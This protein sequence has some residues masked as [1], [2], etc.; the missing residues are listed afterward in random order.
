MPVLRD[1]LTIYRQQGVG[2][3]THSAVTFLGDVLPVERRPVSYNG[4]EVLAGSRLSELLPISLARPTYE[5]SIVDALRTHV[6]QGD[7]VVVVGGGWGVSSVVAAEE[8][9]ES[10][11]VIVYEGAVRQVRRTT[12]TVAHNGVA[13]RA[14]IEHAI[15]GPKVELNGSEGDAGRIHTDELP[16]C[17]VLVLDCEGAERAILRE[18]EVAPSVVIVETHGLF[19]SPT[20]DIEELLTDRGYEITSRDVADEGKSEFC[21]ENDVFVLAATSR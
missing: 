6:S 9:G 10:G 12:E 19:D 2:Q 11:E 7:V 20:A 5:S 4:V 18:M 14:R 1:A 13:D 17:D 16:D 21:R 15:V 8:A 3:L